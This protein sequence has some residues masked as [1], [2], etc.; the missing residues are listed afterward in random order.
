[1]LVFK[2]IAFNVGQDLVWL[3]FVWGFVRFFFFFQ[4]IFSN[5]AQILL[6][7]HAT[8]G[9]VISESIGYV[10]FLCGILSIAQQPAMM[11]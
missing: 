10:G 4:N 9:K 2:K 7:V 11:S 8:G 3:F 6:P 5:K 1:M